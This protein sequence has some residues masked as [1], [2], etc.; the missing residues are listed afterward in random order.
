MA[1]SEDSNHKILL[2]STT[3]PL[4]QI[5]CSFESIPYEEKDMIDK[6]TSSLR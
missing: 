2:L 1:A 3:N 6:V 4:D 5:E